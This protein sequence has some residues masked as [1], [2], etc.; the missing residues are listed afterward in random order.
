MLEWTVTHPYLRSLPYIL[1]ICLLSPL[2]LR[3]NGPTPSNSTRHAQLTSPS[4]PSA[5]HASLFLSLPYLMSPYRM[6]PN[7]HRT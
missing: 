5:L 3:L 4:F 2:R 6:L 7:P 1:T